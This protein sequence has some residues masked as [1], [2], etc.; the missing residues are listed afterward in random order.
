MGV[1]GQQVM[2]TATSGGAAFADAVMTALGNGHAIRSAREGIR[3]SQS[4]LAR[5]MGVHPSFIAKVEAG[6]R[7]MTADMT[8]RAWAAL[9]TL[10]EN[11]RRPVTIRLEGERPIATG[12]EQL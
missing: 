6:E 3:V 12:T 4:A 9:A 2:T 10:D 7:T 5:E 11:Y 1:S 8:Q